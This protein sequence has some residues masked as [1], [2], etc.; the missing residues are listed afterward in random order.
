[1]NIP[2]DNSYQR[3]HPLNGERIAALQTRYQADPAWDRPTDP[4]LEARFQRVRGKL[5][6][7]VDDPQLVTAS[8]SRRATGRSPARYARAYAYHR[9]AHP[10]EA[11]RRGRRPCSRPHR[12][13][14]ISSS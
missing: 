14:P 5:T 12:T 13:I 4:A 1:M 8:L 7:Y 6:G 9:T 11:V 3:T 2:Q 10:D